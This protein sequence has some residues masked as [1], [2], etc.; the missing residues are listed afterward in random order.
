VSWPIPFDV[1]PASEHLAPNSPWRTTTKRLLWDR[2]GGHGMI[3]NTDAAGLVAVHHATAK[4]DLTVI[5]VSA[6]PG[7]PRQANLTRRSLTAF[8]RHADALR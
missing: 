7:I 3:V 4:E 2:H 6:D 1:V 5:S 8:L